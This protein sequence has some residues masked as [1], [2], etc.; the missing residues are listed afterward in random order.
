MAGSLSSLLPEIVRLSHGAGEA[1]LEVYRREDFGTRAKA[2]QSPLTDA[3]MAAHDCILRGLKDLT[4]DIPIL[5][6]ESAE[7]ETADRFSWQRFWLVDPLDGTK[8]FVNRNDQFT[9]NIALVENGIPVLGVLHAPA[10][11]LTYSAAHKMGAFKQDVKAHPG[12]N[13]QD[14]PPVKIRVQGQIKEPLHVAASRSHSNA[15]TAEFFE[16]LGEEWEE[17]KVIPVGSALKFGLVAEGIAHLYPRF[18][19]TMEWDTAAAQC[20]VEQAGGVVVTWAGQPLRYNKPNL[21]NPYFLAACK[22]LSAF[23]VGI[24]AEGDGV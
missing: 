24:P 10:L 5:S 1:I 9:V 4:P 18:G 14:V 20:I 16:Q 19:P 8:E 11:G 22:P 13:S 15:Q 7:S 17:I 21:L 2:D 23:R 3:D 12:K 6:E